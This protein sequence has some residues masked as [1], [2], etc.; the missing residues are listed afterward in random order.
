MWRGISCHLALLRFLCSSLATCLLSHTDTGSSCL[1]T[2]GSVVKN[3]PARAGDARDLSSII[4]SERFLGVAN[5]NCKM[6]T[7]PAISINKKCHCHQLS[8]ASKCWMGGGGGERGLLKLQSSRCYHTPSGGMQ[9]AAI[10]HI[11]PSLRRTRKQGL[12]QDSQGAY[13]RNEFSESRG[14]HLPIQRMLNSLIWYLTLMFSMPAPFVAKVYN[15][16]PLPF[17][18]EQ[19]SQSYWDAVSRAGDS[20]TK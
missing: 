16:I 11:C 6:K 19:F 10:C 9:E 7:S 4:G 14:L 8:L 18:L 3:P 2:D 1:G 15:L 20:P 13:E 5:S 17:S 12:A